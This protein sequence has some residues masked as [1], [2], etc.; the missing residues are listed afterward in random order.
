MK[1]K[2]ISMVLIALCALGYLVFF[3]NCTSN[4]NFSTASELPV[5]AE[6]PPPS[7]SDNS[8][9]DN[10]ESGNVV[11][12]PPLDLKITHINGNRDFLINV[13]GLAITDSQCKLQYQKNGATWSDLSNDF[14]C[15]ADTGSVKFFLPTEDNWT[16]NFNAAGG[17]VSVRIVKS[18]DKSV[19]GVFSKKLGCI[20]QGAASSQTPN[21]D[22]NCNGRWDDFVNGSELPCDVPTNSL[23]FNS[24]YSCGLTTTCNGK[25]ATFK[26]HQWLFASGMYGQSDCHYSSALFNVSGP[27]IQ[28]ESYEPSGLTPDH[29]FTSGNPSGCEMHD[30]YDATFKP[31]TGYAYYINQWI[32]SKCSYTYIQSVSYF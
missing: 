19:V 4:T 16:N 11:S 3:Q 31:V 18:S 8:D 24:P 15:N 28:K 13:T 32:S 26:K 23:T 1:S 9:P 7:S 6:A 30:G 14:L 21:I 12:S 25:P 2:N 20:N 22:E 29:P 17:G 5:V 10:L 27:F